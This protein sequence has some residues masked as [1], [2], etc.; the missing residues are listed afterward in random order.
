M[1]LVFHNLYIQ[2]HEF[3]TP[4]GYEAICSYPDNWTT[5]IVLLKQSK[6]KEIKKEQPSVNARL[7]FEE[8]FKEK[9]IAP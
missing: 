3:D 2:S 7:Q 6:K 4:E 1:K 9:E 5:V 8:F